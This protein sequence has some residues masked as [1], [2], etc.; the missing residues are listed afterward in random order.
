MRKGRED[1][2]EEVQSSVGGGDGPV[3]KKG[4]KRKKVDVERCQKWVVVH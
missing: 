2:D 4:N 1:N 3:K